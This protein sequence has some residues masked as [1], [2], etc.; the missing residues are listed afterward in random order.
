MSKLLDDLQGRYVGVDENPDYDQE[1]A[2]AAPDKIK[3]CVI[4]G[5]SFIK[6]RRAVYCNRQH[7]TTCVNC[8]KRIDITADYFRA[9]FVPKTCCKSCADTVGAQTMKDNCLEKYGVTNPMYVQEYADKAYLNANPNRDLSMRNAKETRQCEVCGKE[10]TVSHTDPKKCC[11]VVCA[12]ALRAQHVNEHIKICKLCGKPFTS[13][14]GKSLYCSGP[15]YRDCVICGKSFLLDSVTSIAQCCSPECKDKLTRQTNL[16]LYGVEI[17]SQSFQARKK[18]SAAYQASCDSRVQTC[19]RK[20]GTVNPAISDTVRQQIANTVASDDCQQK[21]ADTCLKKYG[22]RH[23]SQSSEVH[24]KQWNTR[25]NIRGC[26]GLPLDST[27]ERTVYNFWKSIDLDVERNIPIEFEYAGKRHMTFVDFRVNGILFEVKGNHFLTG[28]VE[29]NYNFPM[30]VK[31]G[32]YRKHNVVIIAKDYSV[33][34]FEDGTLAG[35]DLALF[36][37]I[38][39]FPYDAKTRWT[40]IEYLLKYKKGF[41]SLSD[42]Q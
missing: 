6:N 8:G 18:L 11:S 17:G 24:R 35:V 22:V 39:G 14:F 5:K 26:D 29:E 30:T 32:V 23:S 38:P 36:E 9:G 20:Y 31:L 16:R 28:G 37:D 34:L 42:F 21:I 40:I 15:H 2:N 41:I 27:W 4:C 19:L 10:F 7:Y 3:S 33:Q 12:S 1:V 13:D 25:K